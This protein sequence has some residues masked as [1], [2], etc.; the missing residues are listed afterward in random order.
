MSGERDTEAHCYRKV[1]ELASTAE[2]CREII[3]KSVFRAGD[4][5]AG[6]EVE[7]ASG[8]RRNLL[9]AVVVG[10]RRGEKYRVELMRTH[11]AQIVVRL[12][13]SEIG[14]QNAVGSG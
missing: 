12:F 11:D 6:D 2:Q 5:C 8:Y 4:S 9:Q 1:G 7:K 10:S 14:D 3:G 13:R